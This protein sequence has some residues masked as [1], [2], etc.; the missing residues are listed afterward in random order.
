MRRI[1][2]ISVFIL[3]TFFLIPNSFS[4]I[5][6]QFIVDD[7]KSDEANSLGGK[8]DIYEQEP[9]KASFSYEYMR[10]SGI[11]TQVLAI[12]YYKSLEGGPYGTGGWCGFY[13]MLRTDGRPYF[14]TSEYDYLTLWIKGKK[15]NEDFMVGMADVYLDKKRQTR[16]SKP[17][18]EYLK[19]GKITKYWQKAKIP[20]KEFFLNREKVVS[21]T[22]DFERELFA[23]GSNT[24]TVYID[25][26][27]FEK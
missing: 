10:R 4:L 22:I 18:G 9:S 27:V 13:T 24:G 25:D 3:G 8:T 19:E 16:K 17:I 20:L 2:L 26:I 11:R 21:I 23:N 1:I 5:A 15:G 7:F 14:D 12:K 6:N